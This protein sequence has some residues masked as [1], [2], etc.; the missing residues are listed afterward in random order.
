VAEQASQTVQGEA[1]PSARPA[2]A[3]PSEP[4]IAPDDQ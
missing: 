1:A 4:E 3:T 2:D